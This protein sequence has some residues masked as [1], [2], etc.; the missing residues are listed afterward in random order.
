MK[1]AGIPPSSAGWVAAG[2]VRGDRVPG[3]PPLARPSG[4]PLTRR[5]KRQAAQASHASQLFQVQ[6]PGG[7]AA[8]ALLALA[9]DPVYLFAARRA[10]RRESGA[11]SAAGLAGA[12]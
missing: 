6:P 7:L 2:Y 4:R 10:S 3:C 11:G 8:A 1:E 9:A 5:W 12:A